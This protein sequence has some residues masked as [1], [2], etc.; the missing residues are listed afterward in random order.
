MVIYL[1]CVEMVD[2][3]FFYFSETIVRKARKNSLSYGNLGYYDIFW[4]KFA[5]IKEFFV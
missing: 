2:I 3:T 4:D 1:A 5:I